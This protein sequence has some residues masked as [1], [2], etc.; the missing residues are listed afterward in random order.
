MPFDTALQ[1]LRIYLKAVIKDIKYTF[2]LSYQC[3]IASFGKHPKS[4]YIWVLLVLLIG[5]ITTLNNKYNMIFYENK[6]IF[7]Y[8]CINILGHIA[9]H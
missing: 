1:L 9:M 3:T 6:F 7:P 2:C 4:Q 5:I 8:L